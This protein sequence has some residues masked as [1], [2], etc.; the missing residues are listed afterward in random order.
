MFNDVLFFEKSIITSLIVS[1]Q[2][3]LGSLID[4]YLEVHLE[5]SKMIHKKFISAVMHFFLIFI[6]SI[7]LLYTFKHIYGKV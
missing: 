6:I 5:H 3:L 2:I 1:S 7:I 4:D